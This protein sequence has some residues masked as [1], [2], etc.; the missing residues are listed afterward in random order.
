MQ[1]KR[2]RRKLAALAAAS[3]QQP[4]R[5]LTNRTAADLQILSQARQVP[6]VDPD[7][8][9]SLPCPVKTDALHCSIQ[10]AMVADK[11]SQARDLRNCDRAA[12]IVRV[13]WDEVPSVPSNAPFSRGLQTL[14]TA[15]I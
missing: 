13:L 4:Q 5:W 15:R 2:H 6:Q 12:C 7:L 3:L 1:L 9:H 10:V 14:C 8:S 11:S